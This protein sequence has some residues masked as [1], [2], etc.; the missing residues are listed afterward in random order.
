MCL[1]LFFQQAGGTIIMDADATAALRNKG[2]DTTND[3]FKFTWFQVC[4][5]KLSLFGLLHLKFKLYTV[6]QVS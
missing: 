1:D 6:G 4:R 5:Q 3:S 2:I